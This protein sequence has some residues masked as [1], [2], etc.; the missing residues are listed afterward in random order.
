MSKRIAFLRAVNLG[1]RRVAMARLVQVLEG[2]GYDDVWT[3]VNSGNAVFDAA[4]SRAKIERDV[5]AAL[6]EEFGFDV[7]TFVRTPAEVRKLAGEKPFPVTGNDTHFVTFLRKAPSA[8]AAKQLV[9][10]SGDYDT[11]VVHGRDVHWRMRG[12]SS[13]SPLQKKDWE[14]ILGPNSST[15]R[16]INMLRRLLAKIDARA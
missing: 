15:S 9:A 12:K 8:A 2:L 10:L 5:E 3:F 4:G 6:G 13:D 14:R 1:K 16:N 11:L 7:E